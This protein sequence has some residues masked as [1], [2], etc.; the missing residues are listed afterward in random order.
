[1]LTVRNYREWRLLRTAQHSR[2]LGTP[3]TL[4]LLRLLDSLLDTALQSGFLLSVLLVDLLL[5]V[6]LVR[7]AEVTLSGRGNGRG[8]HPASHTAETLESVVQFARHHP[9]LVGV[10]ACDRRQHLHVLVREQGLVRLA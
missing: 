8:G 5:D 7:C 2:P 1:M 10:T 4:Q 6:D 9:H 3:R